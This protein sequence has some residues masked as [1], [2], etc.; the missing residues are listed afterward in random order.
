MLQYTYCCM[1]S[2]WTRRVP[3][4]RVQPLLRC[5]VIQYRLS[6]RYSICIVACGV[7]V[8]ASCSSVAC[9]ITVALLRNPVAA[10]YMLQYTY[11]LV[12][13][14][15][16]W[17]PNFSNTTSLNWGHGKKSQRW[18]GWS[19]QD[20]PLSL[21]LFSPWSLL[22]YVNKPKS[23]FAGDGYEFLSPEWLDDWRAIWCS[24]LVVE[25]RRGST[26]GTCLRGLTTMSM[27]LRCIV[28]GS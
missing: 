13:N 6:K 27:I 2:P 23:L 17:N 4:F 9:A 11:F 12:T 5:Y 14:C 16:I 25:M 24:T 28:N 19:A 18:W 26:R 1:A 8:D 7:T 21:L 20:I 10:C 22:A 15:M 3:P